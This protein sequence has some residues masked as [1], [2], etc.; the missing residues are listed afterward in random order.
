[1]ASSRLQVAQM[2]SLAWGMPSK[3]PEVKLKC[4]QVSSKMDPG[5]AN[6]GQIAET[7]SCSRKLALRKKGE[8]VRVFVCG[9]GVG[10][11]VASSHL[12]VAQ[13]DPGQPNLGQIAQTNISSRKLEL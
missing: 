9:W 8:C 5:Q 13:M 2:H 7:P 11:P 10:F 1:M 6:P 3:V 4:I 12:Q